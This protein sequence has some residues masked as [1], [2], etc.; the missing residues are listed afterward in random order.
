M[1]QGSSRLPLLQSRGGLVGFG[2][3]TAWPSWAT[4]RAGMEKML[5]PVWPQNL[6]KRY[7]RSWDLTLKM[8]SI[9][10]KNIFGLRMDG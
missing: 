8:E 6:T 1:A 9:A 4:A 5:N 2:T 3:N 7:D 10:N